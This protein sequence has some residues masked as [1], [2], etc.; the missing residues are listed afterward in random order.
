MDF[1]KYIKRYKIIFGIKN[2]ASFFLWAR[3][4]A[5]VNKNYN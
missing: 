4:K 1:K 3:E 2:K 5:N